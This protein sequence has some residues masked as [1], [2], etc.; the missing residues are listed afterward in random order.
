MDN[1]TKAYKNERDQMMSIIET[2]TEIYKKQLIKNMEEELSKGWY[3]DYWDEIVYD[4]TR[5]ERD[6][7]WAKED[8]ELEQ[9]HSLKRNSADIWWEKK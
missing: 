9:E 6:R 5:E 7:R 3:C 4:E 1:E 2:Q 8:E